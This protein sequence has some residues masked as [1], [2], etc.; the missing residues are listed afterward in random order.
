MYNAQCALNVRAFSFS[1]YTL[2][3]I[4]A[5]VNF[6]SISD[7]DWLIYLFVI[8]CFFFF[9]SFDFFLLVA[10][11]HSQSH[12]RWCFDFLF[13]Q[14]FCVCV[15]ALERATT[16]GSWTNEPNEWMCRILFM[17]QLSIRRIFSLFGGCE[18]VVA[19]VYTQ[20]SANGFVLCC[21]PLHRIK[22]IC[23]A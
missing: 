16:F 9:L 19:R 10:R 11:F 17:S 7:L 14:G 2:H 23:T 15:C 1:A 21:L 13:S 3:T 6:F 12:Q 8:F 4:S 18:W 5:W 20:H 22:F